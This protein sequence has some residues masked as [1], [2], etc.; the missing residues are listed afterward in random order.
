M[1]A[2]GFFAFA[3]LGLGILSFA[4]D[5]DIIGVPG[6]GQAPGVI[7]MIVAVVTFAGILS[8][9]VRIRYPR[10]RSVWAISIMTAIAHLL[11]VGIVAMFTSGEFVTGMSVMGGLITGG[12]SLVMLVVAA[13]A[14]WVGVA[15]RRTRAAR[16][17][18]PWE[19]DDLSDGP[20]AT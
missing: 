1:T 14:A 10:F 9:A 16:P 12:S 17:R 4:T 19:K 11:A 15:L 6:L 8:Q 7:G 18:W 3:T 2:V 20:D 5:A 13:I